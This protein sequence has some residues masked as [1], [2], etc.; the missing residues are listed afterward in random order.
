[1][2]V[3]AHPPLSAGDNQR[4]AVEL[5]EARH[6]RLAVDVLAFHH[7]FGAEAVLAHL[8]VL[9]RAGQ[10]GSPLGAQLGCSLG[11]LA[12]FDEFPD[13]LQ[14]VD[15]TLSAGVDDAGLLQHRQ[16]VW[17]V[18]ERGPGPFDAVLQQGADI[19]HTGRGPFGQFLRKVLE[20]GR[21]RAWHGLRHRRPGRFRARRRSPCKTFGRQQM[22]AP[23]ALTEAMKELRHDGARIAPRSVQGCIGHVIHQLVHAPVGGGLR[24]LQDGLER[25]RHVGARV[26]IR[27][28]KDVDPVEVLAALEYVADAG[29]QRAQ[30][31][32]GIQVGDGRALVLHA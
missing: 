8:E 3:D 20:Y 13:T 28:R 7:A 14:Q 17:R 22:P 32:V 19:M 15:E 9:H 5:L 12:L 6:D 30:Q 31:A 18:G 21:Q 4:T 23:D 25:E 26:A 29:C 24:C 10:I 2:D 1:M 11:D 27:H 16:L